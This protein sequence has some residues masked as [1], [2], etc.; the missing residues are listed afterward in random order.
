VSGADD[1]R[2]DVVVLTALD[3]EYQAVR[4]HL[5]GVR[6]H[7]DVSGTR[8]ET[9]E[10]PGGRCRVALARTGEG[11]TRAAAVAS[12]AVPRFQPSALVLVGVAG[13]L[14]DD[15]ELGDVVVATRVHDYQS[16][17][18][19]AGGFRPRGKSWPLARGLEQ[20]AHDVA[21]DGTWTRLLSGDTATVPAVHF[22]PLVSGEALLDSS[23]GHHAELIAE[24]FSDAVAIDMESAG[25][26]EAAHHNDFH[27]TITV[28]AVSDRANGTK[29]DTDASGWQR[30]AVRHAAAFAVALA[31]R[32]TAG[33]GGTRPV[34]ASP[35]RGL[36][37]FGEADAELFF[38]RAESTEA[39]ARMVSD[40]RFVAVVGR[41]GSGKS[42]LV[43]AGL[44]PRVRRRGWAIAAFRPLAGVPPEVALAGG[45]LPLLEPGLGPTET[46][47]RRAVVAAAVAGGR[48]PEVV[49]QVPEATGTS[50]LLVCVDQ[51]EEL[52]AR[53]EEAAG[54]LAALLV[55]LATGPAAAHVVLTVRTETLDVAVHR[56]GLGE[57]TGN[58]VFLLTPMSTEQLRAAVSEPVRSTRVSF[59]PG[60]VARII[61]EARDAP[62]ALTLMQ[63]ALTRLWD[64]QDHGLLTHTAYDAFGGVGGAVA[65]YA[66]QVWTEELGEDERADARRLLLQLV[67]PDGDGAVRRTARGG[68]LA[69]ELIPLATRLATTRL[70][71]TGTDATGELTIDLAHATLA[72]HWRRLHEWLVE[73]RDFRVWQEDL[74]E[75]IRR[76]EPLAGVRLAGAVAWLRTHPHGISPTERDY[77][78]ASRR[79]RTRRNTTWRTA[80]VIILVLLMVVSWFAVDRQQRAS[81]LEDQ[82]RRNAGQVLVAMARDRIGTDPDVAALESVAAY[83]ASQ[84]PTVLANLAA[85]Y[86]RYRD[87]RLVL[88]PGVGQIL[89]MAVS[90]DGGAVA[91]A[92]LDGAAVLYLDGNRTVVTRLGRDVRRVAVSQDGRLV[93]TANDLGRVELRG[94][95]GGV[96]VLR[97]E[98]PQADQSAVLRFDDRGD[99]LLATLSTSGLVVWDTTTGAETIV[100][101][102][103]PAA[104]WAAGSVWFGPGGDSVVM[105]AGRELSSR[106]LDGGAPTT[107]TSL[108]EH[109]EAIVTGDGR[110]A[111]TCADATLEYWDL[112]TG[113][114]LRRLP[115]SNLACPQPVAFATDREGRVT[116][117]FA[118]TESGSHPRHA[119]W[120]VN[121]AAGGP[122][123]VAVPTP[124]GPGAV[125]RPVLARTSDGTRVV[126]AVGTGV[127][128]VDVPEHEYAPAND[129]F[130]ADPL[131]SQ[132]L[133]WA[134]TASTTTRPELGLWDTLTGAALTSVPNPDG[135]VPR[136]FDA[137][138]TRMLAVDQAREH[139]VVFAVPTMDVV[140][141]ITLPAEMARNRDR[142]PGRFNIACVAGLP[143]PRQAAV[144]F[145]GMV[146]RLDVRAGR[147]SGPPVRLWHTEAELKRLAD[148]VACQGRPGRDEIAFDAGPGVELWDLDHG[149]VANLPVNDIG[150][151]SSLRF[152][153][154]GRMLAASG[155]DGTVT[156][157]DLQRRREVLAPRQV[158]PASLD[159]EV[160]HFAGDRM[161][162][163]GSDVVRVWDT[164]RAAAVADV[165]T[166][167]PGSA[168]VSADG[169]TLLYW[170]NAGLTRLPLDP[171][172]W[173][174]HL[175]R[176]VGRDLTATERRDLPPGSPTGRVC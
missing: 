133:R 126:S 8:Y 70:L 60:L 28:R 65:T 39:L 55:G 150:K 132:D 154:D 102:A 50:R 137:D 167:T 86:Q 130:L 173:A 68:E 168:V 161:V 110:M 111:I 72:T 138:G 69:P 75:S 62:A 52:V 128:V 31:E 14:A 174:E 66:E 51:F 118:T 119:T 146:V 107:I 40:H 87:T 108:P 61:E 38:G 112:T 15:V 152:S 10:T 59:E 144:V 153:P 27:R 16:G 92:G 125:V 23:D 159:V 46:L 122:A 63:F 131:F 58:S 43:H 17:R 170:G 123:R 19:E 53:R 140:A 49:G 106:P 57:V 48:L 1:L 81:E 4:R 25:V 82:L 99:R 127:A 103:A 171:G 95:D 134:V 101:G 156:V 139:V 165:E 37:A 93:A 104:R 13:G 151:I 9:G 129:P 67:R 97:A 155:F 41:S 64:E 76:T 169:R 78:L 85:E 124:T 42:S 77:I 71:V 45:L 44:L 21:R 2:A 18:A 163:R 145:A 157:W 74:R 47:S 158:V 84:D 98:G 80:L 34:G 11:N 175:C 117:A 33:P 36:N 32:I 148:T 115:V 89:D 136:W 90:A 172:R 73:E 26:A 135:L 30:R 109:G 141:R 29:R 100:P 147:L 105:A 20:D 116:T 149:H 142:F 121:P 7:V 56:L 166:Q 96:T 24:H 12:Q 79:R 5:T 113:R 35:Y 88:P 164:G 176:I 114:S 83:R 143:A 162:V 94:R 54:E 120:L 91:V 22:K 3:F 6:A 160:K